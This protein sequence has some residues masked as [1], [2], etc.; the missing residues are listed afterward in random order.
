M[1]TRVA[2]LPTC[3]LPRFLNFFLLPPFFHL[4]LI[5]SQV[6][7]SFHF[8]YLRHPFSLSFNN[9]DNQNTRS[10]AMIQ[11]ST[12]ILTL[13]SFIVCICFTANHFSIH[14]LHISIHI[15]PFDTNTKEQ[16]SQL[17]KI[18]T[19]Y[20]NLISISQR[21]FINTLRKNLPHRGKTMIQIT[22]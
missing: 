22:F 3:Q 4:P 16:V 20:V 2:R 12:H 17:L 7:I 19:W 10:C 18:I 1:A 6:L 11:V 15:E 14:Y 8:S 13:I 5:S 9:R 21:T